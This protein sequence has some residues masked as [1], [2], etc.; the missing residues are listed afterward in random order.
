V[1]A[2]HSKAFPDWQTPPEI[3]E[4]AHRLFPGGF[5]DV[6]TA[7]DNPTRAAKF[8]TKEDDGLTADWDPRLPVFCN[9]PGGLVKEFWAKVNTFGKSFLWVGFNLNQLAYL[10]PS[11]LSCG[12]TVVLRYRVRFWRD[13]C[14]GN[15]PT[16]HSYLTYGGL[17][18]PS[19]LDLVE[20]YE[21][22]R[23]HR[24]RPKRG[25]AGPA[26]SEGAR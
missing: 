2:A 18:A 20:E 12:E 22:A 3:V 23:S 14:P 11:P 15:N 6:A 19:F 4:I 7:P 25:P 24:G 9:P 13:G 21:K 17:Y 16:H 5:Q 26:G 10:R 8:L 1:L